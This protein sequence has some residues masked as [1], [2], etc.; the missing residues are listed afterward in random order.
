MSEHTPVYDFVQ[1]DVQ[2]TVWVVDSAPL[3]QKLQGLFAAIPAL[4]IADGHHRCASAVKVGLKRREE[5][6]II[7]GRKNLIFSWRW[8]F[9]TA[10][11]KFCLTTGWCVT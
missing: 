7:P 4:Y 10:S 2:Q 6:R 11:W 3:C 1:D 9:R 5:N 8:R